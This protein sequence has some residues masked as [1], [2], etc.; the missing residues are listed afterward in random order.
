M[1]NCQTLYIT[2]IHCPSPLSQEETVAN[3]G[4]FSVVSVEHTDGVWR[5]QNETAEF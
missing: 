4:T 1:L 5:T 2:T 3:L